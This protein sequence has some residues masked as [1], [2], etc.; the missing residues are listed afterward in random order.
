V[1]TAAG[2]AGTRQDVHGIW[3]VPTAAPVT[4]SQSSPPFDLPKEYIAT[5]SG[6]SQMEGWRARSRTDAEGDLLGTS[7]QLNF[8]FRESEPHQACSVKSQAKAALLA[9]QHA[10]PD[11]P[12]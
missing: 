7:P 3:Y 5:H 1:H 11:G 8:T 9:L 6:D 2:L 4:A 10:K 12:S